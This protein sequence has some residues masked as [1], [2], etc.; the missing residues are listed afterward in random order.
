MDLNE[1]ARRILRHHWVLI[2]LVTLVGLGVPL[3][4]D[5]LQS[6][7]YVATARL[8]IGATDT[9]DGQEANALADTALALATSPEVVAQALDRAGVTRNEAAVAANIKVNPVGTSGVLELSVTDQDPQLSATLANAL[10]AEVV[11]LR[12]ESVLGG[13]QQLIAQ[14][15][16]QIL[17]LTAQIEAIP[18]GVTPE[19]QAQAQA[20]RNNLE[21][22]RS[23]LEAQRRQL[24]Q[25]VAGSVRPRIIDDSMSVGTPVSSALPARLAVGGLLGLILGVALAAAL[26]AW[27]PTLS[28]E[29][30]T[31]HLDA[32]LLGSLPRPPRADT[33]VSDPWVA[34]YLALTA[35]AAAVRS[36]QLVAVGPPVDVS[37]LARSLDERRK[38]GREVSPLVLDAGNPHVDGLRHRR[39]EP[40]TGIVVVAPEIVKA[41]ELAGLE[42]HVQLTKRPVIGVITYSGKPRNPAHRAGGEPQ[43]RE[44]V[45][46]PSARRTAA[47]S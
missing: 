36:I 6:D 8:S 24:A 12:E 9:R 17:E 4:L 46:R 1:A 33:V 35:D 32:P 23:N 42:R 19:G 27:R 40:R 41:S 22:Q 30:L 38:G 15:D 31:R 14:I 26:E 3:L 34:E 18:P 43:P 37:G 2:L 45:D 44:T 29:A 5:R 20:Q 25:N 28:R 13:T 11:A 10:A 21:G 7:S 39:S 47:A 16:A